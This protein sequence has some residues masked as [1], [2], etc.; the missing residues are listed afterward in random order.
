MTFLR[1]G[2]GHVSPSENHPFVENGLEEGWAEMRAGG[3]LLLQ[4][5]TRK[6]ALK[7]GRWGQIRALI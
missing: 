6:A 5:G 2:M 4:A 1:K 7:K 3:R